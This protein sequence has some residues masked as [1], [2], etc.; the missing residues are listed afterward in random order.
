MAYALTVAKVFSPIAFNFIW[1]AKNFLRK[2]LPVYG[3]VLNL[4]H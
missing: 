1:F 2:V 3:P 4:T